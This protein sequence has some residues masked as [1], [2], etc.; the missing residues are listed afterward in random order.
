MK[1][2]N[3]DAAFHRI[4]LNRGFLN[5]AFLLNVLASPQSF[6]LGVLPAIDPQPLLPIK[7]QIHV[8]PLFGASLKVQSVE[9][10]FG[11]NDP[12][13]IE[14][15][16][17]LGNVQKLNNDYLAAEKSFLRCISIIE[18]RMGIFNSGL[19]AP[20]ERLGSLYQGRNQNN[21]AIQI[22]QRAKHITHRNRGLYNSEQIE[23][24]DKLTEAYLTLGRMKD[25]NREQFYGFSV[26]EHQYGDDVIALLPAIFRLAG[27]YRR[28]GQVGSE[29]YVYKATIAALESVKVED[30]VDVVTPLRAIAANYRRAGSSRSE[31]KRT[32]M[33]A[34]GIIDKRQNA[35]PLQQAEI[36]TDLGDW[37]VVSAET[38]KALGFYQSAW[39]ILSTHEQTR[40]IAD[41]IFNRPLVLS[42]GQVGK[43][44]SRQPRLI[45]DYKI[46]LF[47]GAPV[48]QHFAKDSNGY[49]D[50]LPTLNHDI[51][52]ESHI[53][54]KLT[55]K[56]DGSVDDV[57][58]LHML[59]PDRFRV[60]ILNQ[61]DTLRY[62]P[63]MV[64]GKPV[65]TPEFR[66]RL[67]FVETSLL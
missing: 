44:D 10:I 61:L 27:W 35:T 21:E 26:Y 4:R 60:G 28:I 49:E 37:S 3:P 36:L 38:D 5:L 43:S 6:A 59:L 11:P 14:P 31:G 41:R 64:N 62:R 51:N 57:E 2:Q 18:N 56:K 7:P 25:A 23:I 9:R 55:V 50:A 45:P 65:A 40:E 67:I 24:I 34:L 16:L 30:D 52:S 39:Q 42:Y 12:K 20:L 32:L 8:E 58:V 53:E 63:R 47:H 66:S 46:R 19:V 1:Y 29:R 15:L 54:L 48:P 13:L 22:F 17:S 33:Q